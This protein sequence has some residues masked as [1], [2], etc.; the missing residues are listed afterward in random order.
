MSRPLFL[1][2]N[3]D[4]IHAQ[5]IKHLWD[6]F[7]EFADLAIVAPNA[8]RSGSGAAITNFHPLRVAK[9][10]WED[11]TP[12]WSISGTPADCVKMGIT[13]LLPRH[14]D[15]V[16][17][18][19]NCG[20]NSGR[21]LLYSGTVGGAIEGTL[22]GIPSIAF[23]FVDHEFPP[24][25]SVKKSLTTL[26]NHFLTH[27]IPKGSL[28]NINFPHNCH[29]GMKGFRMAKQGRGHWIE[30]PDHRIQPEG[31]PY[32]WLGSR[33]SDH[34]EI[35]PNSDVALLNEG[36]AAVVPVRIDDL[37]DHE[38]LRYHND[39]FAFIDQNR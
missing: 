19:I 20:S 30:N 1:I 8:E 28:I 38:T 21:T 31:V 15:M 12:A 7:R 35:D 6:A 37:T 24:I 5:G 25:G 11:D 33:W 29:K 13:V 9:I 4:G 14:P 36:Y 10:S 39:K 27:P 26:V 32:Y 22:K 3:D 16:L 18:G 2:T 34:E 23:S 17:S